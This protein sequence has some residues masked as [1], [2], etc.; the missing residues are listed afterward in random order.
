M[1]HRE[2]SLQIAVAH[3]LTVVLDP[4]LTWWSSI[5]HGVGRL[6]PAE[7]GIRKRRGVKPGLPDVL[8]MTKLLPLGTRSMYPSVI[9][10]ELKVGKGKLSPAQIEVQDAWRLMGH[11]YYVAT[12]LEEVQEILAHCHVPMRTRMNFMGG[13]LERKPAVRFAPLRYKCPPYRRG[14]KSSMSVVQ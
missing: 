7:A 11:G 6:G 4:S 9:G 13:S 5:D 12:S 1:R 2:H 14:S 8:I 10:I 3:M